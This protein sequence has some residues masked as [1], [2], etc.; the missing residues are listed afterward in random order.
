MV[1]MRHDHDILSGPYMVMICLPWSRRS[2]D[3]RV[4]RVDLIQDPAAGPQNTD[5]PFVRPPRCRHSPHR[6]PN[7]QLATHPTESDL[8]LFRWRG[9]MC[10]NDILELN[11]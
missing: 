2:F 6:P 8:W 11:C 9:E 10:H 7:G 3:L 1:M 4:S 5:A